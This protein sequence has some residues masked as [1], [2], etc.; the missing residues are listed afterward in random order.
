MNAT[1]PRPGGTAVHRLLDELFAD[2]PSTPDALDLKEE[3]RGNL[4]ARATE[5]E[6]AGRTPDEAARIAVDELGDVRELLDDAPAERSAA[7]IAAAHRVRHRPAFVVRTVLIS[8][9]SGLSLIALWLGSWDVFPLST[10]AA[11]ALAAIAGIGLGW[12]IGDSLRRETTV[13]HPM[14]SR[15]AALFGLAGGLVITGVT[16][17]FTIATHGI[18]LAWLILPALAAIAGIGLFSYLGATQTNR[19]KAWMLEYGRSEH[20]IANRFEKDPAAAA[21]FGIYTMLI[22]VAAF[23]VS[24]VIYFAAGWT[25]AWIPYVAGFIGMML[26]VTQMLFGARHNQGGDDK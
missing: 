16:S 10:P 3:V 21:R 17:G 14:P 24:I 25:W 4:V 19:T 13:H 18:E 5:L 12:V 20:E 15:R 1:A 9:A 6:E 23:V 22:W 11:F 2:I 26:L 7:D 8:I